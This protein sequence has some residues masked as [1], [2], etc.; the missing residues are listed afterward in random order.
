MKQLEWL[1]FTAGFFSMIAFIPQVYK[2]YKIKSAQN[3]SIQTFIICTISAVLWI[4]YGF[5]LGNPAVYITNIV[6][7]IIFSVQI[8]LKILYDKRNISHL[9]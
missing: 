3:I 4:T 9:L 5:L 2:T 7:L 6:A 1:G 8:V